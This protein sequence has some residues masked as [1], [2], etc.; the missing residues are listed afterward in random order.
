MSVKGTVRGNVIELDEPLPFADGTRVE[1]TVTPEENIPQR[2]SP[3]AWLQLVGTL[4]HEEA[5]AIRQAVRDIRRIDWEMWEGYDS[6][7][8][9]QAEATAQMKTH[10][11]AH[12]LILV[13]SDEHFRYIDGLS[14]EDR[15]QE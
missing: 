1:V 4:S 6:E 9:P 8:I 2:N 3:Q 10:A 5:E 14:V 12:D 13:T 11:L 7:E 15:T